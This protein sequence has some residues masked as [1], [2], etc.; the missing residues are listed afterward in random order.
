MQM[1]AQNRYVCMRL[2]L[3]IFRKFNI[4]GIF[5]EFSGNTRKKPGSYNVYNFLFE[6]AYISR[7]VLKQVIL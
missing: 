2:G 6:F 4:S 7:S 1:N 3:Y 5:S